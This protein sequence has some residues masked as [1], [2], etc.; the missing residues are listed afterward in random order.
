VDT[1]TLTTIEHFRDHGRVRP[2]VED[3]LPEAQAELA[4]LEN[5]GI[6]YEQ[7]TRQLQDEGVQKF[8]DSFNKLFACIEDKRKVIEGRQ[9]ARG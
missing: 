3:Q 9:V 4:A 8:A 6:S 1:M 2:S 5:V 7:V